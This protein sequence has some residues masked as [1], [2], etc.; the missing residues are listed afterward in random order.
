[1]NCRLICRLIWMVLLCAVSNQQAE[2]QEYP[3]SLQYVTNMHTINPAFVGIWNRSGFMASTKTN[4]VGFKGAPQSQYIG[5]FS[6]IRD[7]KNSGVGLSVQ[8]LNIGYEKRLSITGD[9]SFQIRL[10]MYN[11]LRFGMRAGI[12]NFDN[13][14]TD[15]QLYPDR[16]P[17]DEFNQ[18]IKLYNMTTFGLGV[19]FYNEHLFVSL[20]T[21]QIIKNTFNVNRSIYSSTQDFKTIYLSGSYVFRLINNVNLRP[22]L[23]LASTIGKPVY[24][25]VAGLVYLPSGLQFGINVRSIGSICFSAQYIFK[26]G[27]KMGYASEYAFVSDI[28]K[29]QMGTYE[30]IVGYDLNLYRRKYLKPSYF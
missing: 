8:R 4:W 6:P 14:L 1:M 26:N 9:Y 12:I 23:L 28:R 10:D 3:W 27:I 18:D 30:L 24:Y 21:P 25:D 20:S 22:N 16:I 29:Y 2:G 11:Y 19:V 7:Q 15:Y 5:Y 17:D 13:K